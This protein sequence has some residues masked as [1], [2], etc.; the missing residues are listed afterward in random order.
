MHIALQ[1]N[2]NPE[3]LYWPPKIWYVLSKR[4]SISVF[5]F[6]FNE[7]RGKSCKNARNFKMIEMRGKLR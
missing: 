1:W 4:N 2:I 7:K 6:D 3:Y 5:C